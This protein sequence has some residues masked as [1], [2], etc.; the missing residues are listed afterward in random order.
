MQDLRTYGYN[1]AMEIHLP[2][3]AESKKALN[4]MIYCQLEK[5]TSSINHF[6]NHQLLKKRVLLIEGVHSTEDKYFKYHP[7]KPKRSIDA[8]IQAFDRLQLNYQH[9]TSMSKALYQQ[10]NYSDFIFLCMHGEFGE[11]GKIQGFLDYLNKPYLGAGVLGSAIC[12]DKV[13]FKSMIS[14]AGIP[15][16]SFLDIHSNDHDSIILQKAQDLGYPVMIKLKKGGS[17]LGIYKVNNQIELSSWLYYN[18]TTA[19]SHG[20]GEA[21]TASSPR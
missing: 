19:A 9:I 16:P 8:L 2:L 11:D 18:E 21:L 6:L 15:T 17:S 4:T 7:K 1:R 20:K 14:Q 5:D 3:A 13:I 10:I 12:A